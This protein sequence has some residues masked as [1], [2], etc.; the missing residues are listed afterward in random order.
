MSTTNA[1]NCYVFI[2]PKLIYTTKTRSSAD[3]DKPA[4]C[5]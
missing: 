1:S 5:I 2:S 4:R 3:A